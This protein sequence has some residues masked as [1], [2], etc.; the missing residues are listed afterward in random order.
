MKHGDLR[1]GEFYAYRKGVRGPVQKVA[2]ITIDRPSYRQQGLHQVRGME[3]RH[4]QREWR[5]SSRSLLR[6]WTDYD[7]TM[8]QESQQ[9]A[10]L[11]ALEDAVQHSRRTARKESILQD[12]EILDLVGLPH[13]RQINPAWKDGDVEHYTILI[14]DTEQLIDLVRELLALRSKTR[15]PQYR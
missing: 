2:M 6:V 10:N 9:K 12:M 8:L 7:E 3:P 15:V 13:A 14:L 4:D 1:R 11:R 5:A